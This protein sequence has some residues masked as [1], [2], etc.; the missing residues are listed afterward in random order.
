MTLRG[1]PQRLILFKPTAIAVRYTELRLRFPFSRV[2]S[3]VYR[4]R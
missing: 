2:P 3:G 1:S 4:T